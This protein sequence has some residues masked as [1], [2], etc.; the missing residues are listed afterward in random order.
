M[1]KQASEFQEKSMSLIY[2]GGDDTEDKARTVRLPKQNT[3]FR[4]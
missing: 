2:R 4:M 1:S 3:Q